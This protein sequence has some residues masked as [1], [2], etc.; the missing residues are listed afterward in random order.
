M[1]SMRLIRATAAMTAWRRCRENGQG[2]GPESRGTGDRDGVARNLSDRWRHVK[3][4]LPVLGATDWLRPIEDR[5]RLG[6][7]R[8]GMIE[9]FSLG[10]MPVR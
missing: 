2:V 3:S 8:E 10:K 9:G 1:G 6:S 4:D 5:R 7:P